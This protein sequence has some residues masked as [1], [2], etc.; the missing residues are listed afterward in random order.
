MASNEIIGTW[1]ADNK[2]WSPNMVI[3]K[4]YE[5][6]KVGQE[7]TTSQSS[8]MH[9]DTIHKISIPHRTTNH[10]QLALSSGFNN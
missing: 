2:T 9:V 3:L 7:S 8:A 10:L 6:M 1:D 4:Q 5:T